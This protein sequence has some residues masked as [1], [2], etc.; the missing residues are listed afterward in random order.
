V[1]VKKSKKLDPEVDK[2]IMK[3][4]GLSVLASEDLFQTAVRDYLKAI[5]E[6]EEDKVRRR[7]RRRK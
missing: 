4:N 1:A 6:E 7:G 3:N 5:R 2:A